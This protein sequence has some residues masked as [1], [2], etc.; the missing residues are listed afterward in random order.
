MKIDTSK[1]T[2]YSEM[3]AEDKLKAL[4]EYE[5]EAP[6]DNSEEVKNLKESLSKA[7]SQ[8][9]E[10]KRQFREKQTEQER[11]E[12]E[13]A[14]REKETAEKLASYERKFKVSDLFGQY[15]LLGYSKD[16][17]QKAAEATADGNTAVVMEC[18]QEFLAEKQKELEAAA[19]NKQPTITS[20]SPPTAKQADHDAIN[21]ERAWFGLPPLK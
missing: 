8:A 3:S 15:T 10:W 13:R 6:K 16:L 4:E 2:G 14:E 11:A 18:Q 1:I 5:F 17:A 19:L 7:N 12:A 20:G 9:A 21:R